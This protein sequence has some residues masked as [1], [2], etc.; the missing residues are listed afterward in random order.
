MTEIDVRYDTESDSLIAKEGGEKIMKSVSL[1]DL[2]LDIGSDQRVI[3]L[4]VLNA[5]DIVKMSADLP[6]P[7]RFLENVG[8]ASLRTTYHEDGVIV[9]LRLEGTSHD[10]HC[11]V[12]ISS[13]APSLET[14]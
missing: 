2:T 12:P 14:A 5:S 1:G 3:G 6:D 11:S 13:M 10:E 9:V 7:V 8:D 4:Q